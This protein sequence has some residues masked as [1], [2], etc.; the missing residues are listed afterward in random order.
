MKSTKIE[1]VKTSTLLAKSFTSFMQ[2]FS[3]SG[4]PGVG[5]SSLSSL[6][7]EKTNLKYFDISKFAIEHECIKEYDDEYK[8]SVLNEDKVR[9]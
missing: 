9:Y 7:A 2:Y 1:V 4:T 6:L 8:S 5:K 3:I